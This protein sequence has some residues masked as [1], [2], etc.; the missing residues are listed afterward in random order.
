[1][2]EHANLLEQIFNY[3]PSSVDTIPGRTGRDKLK[4]H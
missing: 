1:M 3:L 4:T 2:T